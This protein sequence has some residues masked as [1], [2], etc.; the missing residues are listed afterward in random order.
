MLKEEQLPHF[1]AA[2][3]STRI[4][5]STMAHIHNQPYEAL[6]DLGSTIAS[7]SLDLVNSL[8][9]PTSSAPLI[10]VGFGD[11]QKLY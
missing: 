11:K 9:L 4:V 8:H 3:S 1:Q 6:L 7:I 10:N 2:T 5:C